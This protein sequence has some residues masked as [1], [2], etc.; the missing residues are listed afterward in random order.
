MKITKEREKAH[1]WCQEG[2]TCIP[3]SCSPEQLLVMQH[4]IVIALVTSTASHDA[5]LPVT[6][7][8]MK[9]L[10]NS[11]TGFKIFPNLLQIIYLMSDTVL[12]FSSPSLK[13]EGRF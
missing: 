12:K 1:L 2:A 13:S 5:L 9:R 3:Y 7:S 8:D 10:S 11:N 4:H 6:L